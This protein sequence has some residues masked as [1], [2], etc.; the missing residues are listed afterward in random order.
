[1]VTGMHVQSRDS[2]LGIKRLAHLPNFEKNTIDYAHH[3]MSLDSLEGLK[4][5]TVHN[6]VFG[7]DCLRFSSSV[8]FLFSPSYLQG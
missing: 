6:M 4:Y 8:R 2:Q 5:I 3:L 7:F 1:M